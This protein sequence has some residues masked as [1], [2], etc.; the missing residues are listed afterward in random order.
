M[1]KFFGI[2]L[3]LLIST[4]LLC[5][6]ELGR[7]LNGAETQFAKTVGECKEYSFDMSILTEENQ[8]INLTCVKKNNDY[9]YKYSLDGQ[10]YPTYRRMFVNS[11]QYDILE[12]ADSFDTPFGGVTM[13]TGTYYIT[14]NVSFTS[15]DNVLYTVSEN[16]LTA[17]YLTLVKSAT[18]EKNENGETLFRYDF[19]YEQDNYS[20]WFDSTYLRRVKI[21]YQDNTFY[22]LFFSAFR[23]GSVNREC[24]I[25]PEE[26]AGVYVKSP[27]SFQEWEKILGDF[28]NKISG[29]LPK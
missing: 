23:F 12:V 18:K 22:D 10:S 7:K 15:K 5:G 20:F 29:C 24:L 9:A 11:C 13:G 8:K 26:T 2:I 21:V 3:I 27:I 14:E 17:T 6:C 4:T 16:L 25:K 19:T 28:S 1:R